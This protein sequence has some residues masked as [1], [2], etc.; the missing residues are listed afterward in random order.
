MLSVENIRTQKTHVIHWSL[1]RWVISFVWWNV[2]GKFYLWMPRESCRGSQ[3]DM[4]QK[5]EGTVTTPFI[6]FTYAVACNLMMHYQHASQ[7]PVH[8]NCHHL[9]SSN[10]WAAV[11]WAAAWEPALLVYFHAFYA[12]LSYFI[13]GMERIEPGDSC[14]SHM[15]VSPV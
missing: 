7:I 1:G 15:H 14:M 2:K 9:I 6:L 5:P 4:V 12:T 13:F 3:K 8:K 10:F 11:F